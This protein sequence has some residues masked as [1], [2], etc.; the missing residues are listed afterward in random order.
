MLFKNVSV[1]I[2]VRGSIGESGRIPRDGG[3]SGVSCKP[4]PGNSK[5]RFL[6]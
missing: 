3:F 4:Q 5:E 1:Q 6:I 2:I